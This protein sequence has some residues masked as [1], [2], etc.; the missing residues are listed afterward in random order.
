M[1]LLRE[2]HL[3]V[4]LLHT[5]NDGRV[6]CYVIEPRVASLNLEIAALLKRGW[7]EVENGTAQMRGQWKRDLIKAEWHIPGHPEEEDKHCLSRVPPLYQ[8][9]WEEATFGR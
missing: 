8:R 1:T 2:A 3:W 9:V 4:V 7:G 6:A 5:V